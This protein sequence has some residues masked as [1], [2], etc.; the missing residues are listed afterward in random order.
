MERADIERIFE[1]YHEKFKKT[2]GDRSSW[3]AV[4]TDMT[5]AG[6]LELNLT[7]CPRGTIFK[8]FVDKRKAAEIEG[9]DAFFTT[10][11]ALD[12]K[13]PGLYDPDRLFEEM[14]SVI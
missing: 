1:A 4:W 2:E 7:K 12:V 10:M 8:V 13:H 3:S 6:V 11:D 14:A 5:P 9:W